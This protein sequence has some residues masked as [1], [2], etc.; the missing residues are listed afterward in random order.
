MRSTCPLLAVGAAL[1]AT[2]CTPLPGG[3]LSADRP[4]V[5][6]GT[7]MLVLDATQLNQGRGTLLSMLTS[8]VAQLRVVAN[9]VCPS[10]E[11]RGR[12]SI[13]GSSEPSIYLDG[14]R[15]V[16]TCVLEQLSAADLERVEIYPMGITSRPGYRS[17]SGGLILLF[18]RDSRY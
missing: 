2:A 12:T 16:N 8:R 3:P 7:S 9:G 10:L 14:T 6:A 18:S 1:L 17:S 4:S 11:M 5:A 13:Y 15:A